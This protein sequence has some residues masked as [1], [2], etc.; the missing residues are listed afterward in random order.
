MGSDPR[1]Y[2]LASAVMDNEE[3]VQCP[4]PNSLNRKQVAGPYLAAVLGQ[5]LSPVGGGGS[6]VGTSHVSGDRA[7]TDLEANTRQ[8]CLDSALAPER[9]LT[10]HATNEGSEL[11]I[12]LFAPRFLRPS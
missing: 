12:S 8:L 6:V 10:S 11:G 7:R 9:I 5:K 4:K 3:D 1:V 2:D